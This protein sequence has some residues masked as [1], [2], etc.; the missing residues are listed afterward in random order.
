MVDKKD[1]RVARLKL[2]SGKRVEFVVD[3]RFRLDYK[4]KL[5]AFLRITAQLLDRF[6]RLAPDVDGNTDPAD[7]RL[8][9]EFRT[10]LDEL[11]FPQGA[12][13]VR[14]FKGKR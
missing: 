14:R 4:Q 11:I 8:I 12:K 2:S 7:V 9:K 3:E 1:I 10:K 13:S 6:E 5:R